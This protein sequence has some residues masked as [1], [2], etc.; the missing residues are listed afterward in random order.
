MHRC[1][2]L[3]WVW[4]NLRTE[5]RIISHENMREYVALLKRYYQTLAVCR[6]EKTIIL[7]SMMSTL[8]MCNI[9]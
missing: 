2:D 7:S 4:A 5:E 8:I 1:M 6:A 9:L 3:D